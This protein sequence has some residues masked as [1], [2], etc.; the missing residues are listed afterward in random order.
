[1]ENPFENYILHEFEQGVTQQ[2]IEEV[3]QDPRLLQ[4]LDEMITANP[5]TY[6]MRLLQNGT[7]LYAS[8]DINMIIGSPSNNVTQSQDHATSSTSHS[9]PIQEHTNIPFGE[10]S[11]NTETINVPPPFGASNVNPMSQPINMENP[12]ASLNINPIGQN[13]NVQGPRRQSKIHIVTP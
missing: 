9:N 7:K 3:A 8:V 6:L 13:M 1:M 12:F 2:E 5:Q 10:T 11:H 4:I